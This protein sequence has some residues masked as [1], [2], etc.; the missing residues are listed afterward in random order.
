MPQDYNQTLNLPK[1][2]FPMRGNLPQREPEMLAD[3]EEKRSYHKLIEKNKGK[4]SYILHDGPPYANG[5]IHIG[6]ALNKILKDIVVKY[7]NMSGFRSVFVPGWDMH[8]LPTELKALKK[9]GVENGAVDPLV[10]R[11]HCREFACE[12]LN[13]QREQFKR[14]GVWGDWDNPY[15]TLANSFEARQ[16]EVFGEIAKQGFIYKGLKPVYWC[17]DCQTALAEAE[18][19]Y[20]QDSTHS[21]YVKFKLSDD[22]GKLANAGI[23]LDKASVVIW[24]TTTWTLPGNLAICLGPNFEYTFVKHDGEYLLMAK[25][26]V[27]AT[28][29]AAGIT[30]YETVGTFLGKDFEYMTVEHPFLNRKSLMI[31]G[32]HVTLESGTGCVHTAPGHGHEDYEVCLKY[33]EIGIVVPVDSKG[34]LTAEAGEFVGLSTKDANKAIAKKLEQTGHLHAIQKIIHQYP[35]CWRCREPIL[36]RATEQWFCSVEGFKEAT[37]KAIDDV[38]WI[39]GWGG[40]RIKSMVSERNDWCISRQRSWGVPI[41]I[42]YCKDCGKDIVNDETISAISKLFEAEGSDAWYKKDP[43]EFIPASVKCECG[44]GEFTKEK[45][46]MD[47][48]FDSGS[49]H[50]AVLDKREDLTW[51]A[52]LYL[53]GGDQYRGWFQSSLLTAVAWRGKAPYKAVCT[54]GWTVDGDGRKMSKS[55]GNTVEPSEIIKVYGADILRLWIASL[56]YHSDNRISQEILKQISESYRKIRNTARFILGNLQSGTGFNPDS[57]MVAYDNLLELDKWALMKLD[58]LIERVTEAY[59]NLDFHIV[60]HSIHRFCVLDMSNFYL[61]IIKDRLYCEE[62]NSLTRKA[63]QTVMYTILDAL[64]RLIAPILAYTSDEIWQ[65]MPHS[66]SDDTECVVYN[67][68]PKASGRAYDDSFKNKWQQVYEIR[69]VVKKAL[70]IKRAEKFIGASLEAKATLYCSDKLYDFTAS[71]SDELTEIFIVSSVEVAKGG[72]GEISGELEGLSVTISRADGEKCERCWVY[73]ESVGSDE[74]HPT[75]CKRCATVTADML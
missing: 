31:V 61:D 62:D 60:Y 54:H 16:V 63:A 38:K 30:E 51:P 2:D 46:I 75:L 73:S 1:T 23:D 58:E 36:Y 41:P 33:K 71:I 17:P 21:I 40:E 43:S 10:I 15:M 49:S 19:E 56:D 22:K 29:E 39:P 66:K 5:D 67:E 57:D 20:E 68:M 34:K 9:V 44:C 4:P 48:W 12:C 28:M 53:E 70:E 50:A 42:I 13:T 55:L 69:E 25:D 26:L 8:G 7:K 74:E 35:H 64:T 37:L 27:A 32:D 45:D 14:L 52:D 3:W 18:I 24:T 6:T 11:K 47:V 72:T 65:H 59:E